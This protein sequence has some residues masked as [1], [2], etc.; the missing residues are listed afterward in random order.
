MLHTSFT[1]IDTLQKDLR[2]AIDNFLNLTAKC[3]PSILI[4]K[5]KF[6]FL[7]HLPM[8]I[9]RFGPAIVFS[10]ERYESFNSVF[11][12]SC[13]NSNR[14]APSRDTCEHLAYSDT[15]KH[16]LSGGY[17]YSKAHKL[18][19]KA[20]PGVQRILE[21]TPEIRDIMG[22]YKEPVPIKVGAATLFPTGKSAKAASRRR[23]GMFVAKGVPL[24]SQHTEDSARTSNDPEGTPEIHASVPQPRSAT[25]W[26]A[27]QCGS[28]SP[29][30][31]LASA[32]PEQNVL[33]AKTMVAASGD[34]VAT[35]SHVIY[36]WKNE[37][38]GLVRLSTLH[39][40]R[41]ALTLD[42]RASLPGSARSLKS[43]LQQAPH[44]FQDPSHHMCALKT[45]HL[46]G[47]GIQ[48]STC[49]VSN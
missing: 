23:G 39:L 40:H 10:T 6:H 20:G 46:S 29:A 17:W 21:E 2:Q 45:W 22:L 38:G 43:S 3:S 42:T 14:Q 34:V 28:V 4:S 36:N 41:P 33:R 1:L 7:V 9:E 48:S 19:V 5:P 31:S 32:Q 47:N 16:I 13:I 24:A 18:W 44:C 11:R 49:H 30:D 37:K 12:A 27:T 8:Y 35:S 25:R 26:S 15:I